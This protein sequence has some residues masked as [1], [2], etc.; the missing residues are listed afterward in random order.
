MC[1]P[2][3]QTDST[4]QVCL[5]LENL[6]FEL[7]AM[8]PN[9]T[10]EEP[11]FCVYEDLFECDENMENIV[12]I[13]L[14]SADMN[15]QI[16]SE[17]IDLLPQTIETLNLSSNNF[18]GTIDFWNKIHRFKKV[19]LSNNTFTGTVDFSQIDL[20]SQSGP[21]RSSSRALMSS[22]YSTTTAQTKTE[23]TVTY[24]TESVTTGLYATASI[25]SVSVLT[26]LLVNNN[27]FDEQSI[28]WDDFA[29]FPKL[30]KLDL[31]NNLFTGTIEFSGFENIEYLNVA[32]NL[33]DDIYGFDSLDNQV[34]LKELYLNNNY[35]R[36]FF[37]FRYLPDNMEILICANNQLSL[38][39]TM[40]DMPKTLKQFICGDNSFAEI[41]W[42]P[43]QN[44]IGNPYLL[45]TLSF[46]TFVFF[47]FTYTIRACTIAC[48]PL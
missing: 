10:L 2:V 27:N 5:F 29:N 13:K 23:T 30:E 39:L 19:D 8:A 15:G 32:N 7:I 48:L 26:E 41:K 6:E 12:N 25:N 40:N 4:N 18:D 47:T 33:F 45:T 3:L 44:F 28:N 21:A 38:E 31:S 43:A 14:S 17:M 16:T 24:T 35:I 42:E 22:N 46:A 34:S 9:F 37:E 1:D 20:T 11:N 36:T